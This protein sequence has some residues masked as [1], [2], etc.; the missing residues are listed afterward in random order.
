MKVTHEAHAST[1]DQAADNGSI[2]AD[3]MLSSIRADLD[4]LHETI[5]ALTA[6]AHPERMERAVEL[7]A[8]AVEA[9]ADASFYAARL[10][11]VVIESDRTA[12][13]DTLDAAAEE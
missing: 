13:D 11:R 4:T 3:E 1:N 10:Q 9:F 7:A 12:P 6:L 5:R 2:P 8:R